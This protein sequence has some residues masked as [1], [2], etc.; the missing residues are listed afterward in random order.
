ML[1]D[2]SNLV[3]LELTDGSKFI[4]VLDNLTGVLSHFV[5]YLGEKCVL[6]EVAAGSLCR[7]CNVSVDGTNGPICHQFPAS[8]CLWNIVQCLVDGYYQSIY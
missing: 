7:L 5:Q 4:H 6:V 2:N 3:R 1:S 8:L